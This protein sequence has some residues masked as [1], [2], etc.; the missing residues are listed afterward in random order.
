MLSLL[1]NPRNTAAGHEFDYLLEFGISREHM[2]SLNKM[3]DATILLGFGHCVKDYHL[4]GVGGLQNGSVF[5]AGAKMHSEGFTKKLHRLDGGC[6][7]HMARGQVPSCTTM[8]VFLP[9]I[10]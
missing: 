4:Q 10:E 8:S 5:M 1:A 9:T 6:L 7:H 3:Y 2:C